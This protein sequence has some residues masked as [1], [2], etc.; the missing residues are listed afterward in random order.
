MRRT[1]IRRV[2]SAIANPTTR[3]STW[4]WS[5]VGELGHLWQ[6]GTTLM[7]QVGGRLP[8]TTPPY[9]FRFPQF[10]FK[11]SK[12]TSNT[13]ELTLALFSES[14]QVRVTVLQHPQPLPRPNL[15][16]VRWEMGNARVLRMGAPVV[17]WKERE[18]Q[19]LLGLGNLI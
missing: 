17:Q 15:N 19:L 10:P 1:A 5:I 13:P 8:P 4:M 9:C 7:L 18:A 14:L 11:I 3:A 2:R 12:S 16:P 6:M